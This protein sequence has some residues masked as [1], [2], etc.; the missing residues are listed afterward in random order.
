MD[1]CC[2]PCSGWP[3]AVAV[4]GLLGFLVACH[5][6]EVHAQTSLKPEETETEAYVVRDVCSRHFLIHT[7]LSPDEADDFVERL[8]TMLGQI[9]RYWGRP[10]RGVIECYVIRDM[11]EFPVATIAPAGVRGVKTVG[12]VTLM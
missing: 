12:G 10:V 3:R 7:D 4:V 1:L 11:D 5:V 6:R 2:V 9:S 8:E